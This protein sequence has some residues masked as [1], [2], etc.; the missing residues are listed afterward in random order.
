MIRICNKKR[1]IL[2]SLCAITFACIFLC[3]NHNIELK[4]IAS[5][6]LTSEN[7]EYVYYV[8]VRESDLADIYDCCTDLSKYDF[9]FDNH[10][11][12]ISFR[13]EIV[14]LSYSLISKP[15]FHDYDYYV[16]KVQLLNA[17]DNLCHIYEIPRVNINTDPDN[18][19]RNVSFVE[20]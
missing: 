5:G 13:Y 10:S 19:K 17:K 20:K 2:L 14:G 8:I 9:D 6:H 7:R 11:Y 1:I 16:P 3:Y 18:Y 4:E 12:I 15:I